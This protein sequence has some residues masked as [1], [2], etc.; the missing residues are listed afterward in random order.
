MEADSAGRGLLSGASSAPTEFRFCVA[1]RHPG[2]VTPGWVRCR[3]RQHVTISGMDKILVSVGLICRSERWRVPA[4][5]IRRG[6]CPGICLARW[7]L[8]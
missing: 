3:S 5:H 7:W 8:R 2:G 1:F 4:G 6:R